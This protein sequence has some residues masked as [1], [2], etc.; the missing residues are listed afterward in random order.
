MSL[1]PLPT[2]QRHSEI[3]TGL[4]LLLI[5]DMFLL[6]NA[7]KELLKV[8]GHPA[9]V[10]KFQD[11]KSKIHE[12]MYVIDNA[13]KSKYFDNMLRAAQV[14]MEDGKT[15]KKS[16]A[17]NRR[18]WCAIQ[19]VHLV[20]N[21]R[22]VLN[23]ITHEPVIEYQIFKVYP[24]IDG[25]KKPAIKGNP[26]DNSGIASGDFVV[27]RNI[28]KATD[29]SKEVPTVVSENGDVPFAKANSIV[30][31]VTSHQPVKTTTYVP[32]NEEPSFDVP[33]QGTNTQSVLETTLVPDN[34]QIIDIGD[35]IPQF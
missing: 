5:A 32:D 26:E 12:Q 31:S 13:T 35:Q 10:V 29:L 19:E 17:V 27:Y 3:K 21:D 20:D 11:S 25:A 16:D 30:T 33:A 23:E 15:P 7:S 1:S 14:P 4:H 8:D 34:S 28:S 2:R 22:Q 24:F 9:I 6:K 18:L